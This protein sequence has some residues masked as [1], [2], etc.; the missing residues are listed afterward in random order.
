MNQTTKVPKHTLKMNNKLILKINKQCYINSFITSMKIK[1][2]TLTPEKSMVTDC[3]ILE[4]QKTKCTNI[5]AKIKT[6]LTP[7]A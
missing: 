4:T 3:M 6:H 1:M 5:E 7:N 2:K